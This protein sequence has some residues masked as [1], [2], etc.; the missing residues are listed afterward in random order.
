MALVNVAEILADAGYNVVVCDFD[1]EAPGL[2]RY[3]FDTAH[4][5]DLYLQYPGVIDLLEEYRLSL[6]EG[7]ET[8]LPEPFAR[9]HRVDDSRRKTGSLR[10]LAAGRRVGDDEPSYARKVQ[11]FNW[12]DFYDRWAGGAYIE[13]FRENLNERADITLIDSRTGVTEHGGVCTHH[14]AD[15]DVLLTAANDL[16]LIGTAW[17]APR[18]SRE[19]VVQLRNG[20]QLFILPVASRIEQSSQ[21][22]ELTTFRAN[23][24]TTFARFVPA[25]AGDSSAI[26][27]A[28]EIP[29]IPFYAFTERVVA[30]EPRHERHRELYESYSSLA[31]AI[32][33]VG[34]SNQL[35]PLPRQEGW[36]RPPLKD[37]SPT[38]GDVSLASALLAHK[39]WLAS[40]GASGR[41]A[42]LAE[43]DLTTQDLS[44]VVLRRADFRAAKLERAALWRADLTEADLSRASLTAAD[45]QEAILDGANLQDANLER[46][47]LREAKAQ[48]SRFARAQLRFADLKRC[49][50]TGSDL[51]EASLD[52]ADLSGA[53]LTGVV[54][55]TR[56]QIESAIVD[57][58]TKLPAW[59]EAD[60]AREAGS[61]MVRY[62]GFVSH[63]HGP[64]DRLV[65]RLCV[66]LERL[67]IHQNR[68]GRSRLRLF[69]DAT[70]PSKLSALGGGIE[71][72]IRESEFLLLLASPESAK[73]PWTIRE[74]DVW[75]QHRSIEK[76]LIVL[77]AGDIAWNPDTGD[78]D[79][80]RT[81][82]LPDIVRGR[83]RDLPFYIDLRWIRSDV[84]RSMDHPQFHEAVTT[85]AA[86]LTRI[87]KD[88]LT[89]ALV[90]RRRS[91]RFTFTGLLAVLA[92]LLVSALVFLSQ[93]RAE[94]A[95]EVAEHERLHRFTDL[96]TVILS[97]AF[98][99]DRNNWPVVSDEGRTFALSGGSYSM[100][101]KT[102]SQSSST[103]PIRMIDNSDFQIRCRVRKRSGVDNYFFG[104]LWRMRDDNNFDV[105]SITGEGQAA[106]ARRRQGQFVD[107]IDNGVVRDFVNRGNTVNELLI[108]KEGTRIRFF[109]NNHQVHEMDYETFDGGRIGF[110]VY[111]TIEVEFDDLVV[112]GS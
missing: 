75:L 33:S 80:T 14:L 64:D 51:T 110:V 61:S 15:L 74:V 97:E 112:T 109:V 111:N 59:Y 27:A 57:G 94:L 71:S 8:L 83:Y 108:R 60:V 26:L 28:C 85:I 39:E 29:Y 82:A 43:R 45:L 67:P 98:D 100:A 105:L 93:T 16:N 104:L 11:E 50:L 95:N 31:Q 13:F 32:V 7:S 17:M 36:L 91:T 81:T 56:R 30:R 86:R 1:L 84:H 66:A 102:G 77:T 48:G 40:S 21:K 37:A 70:N 49:D 22:N 46:A 25:T 18:L 20:R 54:G 34:I 103:I 6:T 69:R 89:D 23:F 52:Q 9:T 19:S 53:L 55:L 63:T 96:R 2:E 92:S 88:E 101:S 90:Q 106:V 78:F 62:D 5:S 68:H 35:L 73:S 87:S 41:M 47:S 79:W 42:N 65:P 24:L 38:V 12:S 44:N 4:E 76:V 72:A 58:H 3:L 10:L 99:D 107:L